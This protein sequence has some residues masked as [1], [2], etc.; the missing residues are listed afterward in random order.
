MLPQIRRRLRVPSDYFRMVQKVKE[1]R[2]SIRL[3]EYA[4]DFPESGIV[5][6]YEY[7]TGRRL[8]AL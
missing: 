6:R 3:P 1:R 4:H 8:L 7:V 5:A 2:V